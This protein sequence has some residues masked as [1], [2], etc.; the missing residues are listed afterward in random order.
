MT[1]RDPVT[2]HDGSHLCDPLSGEP[3]ELGDELRD[4]LGPLEHDDE[5][6]DDAIIRCDGEP[7]RQVVGRIGSGVSS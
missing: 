1:W 7:D 4:E 2:S 5:T 3:L 6:H